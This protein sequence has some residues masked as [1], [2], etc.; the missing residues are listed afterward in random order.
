MK[1]LQFFSIFVIDFCL[2]GFKLTKIYADP[3]STT[4]QSTLYGIP[5][6]LNF[7]RLAIYKLK[8]AAAG[9]LSYCL[10]CSEPADRLEER[11]EESQDPT[12][13]PGGWEQSL[14]SAAQVEPLAEPPL[15]EPLVAPLAE[16]PTPGTS[17]GLSDATR[18][19]N[20]DIS[21]LAR[22]IG[23]QETKTEIYS[24]SK[25]TIAI[26]YSSVAEPDPLPF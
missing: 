13:Q 26:V 5:V 8:C 24:T 18:R 2:P 3:R 25:Q 1:F 9:A 14:P 17:D 12:W 11:G 22:H 20:L 6:V 19:H 23:R 7:T 15:E 4:M 16:E 21:L 10:Y